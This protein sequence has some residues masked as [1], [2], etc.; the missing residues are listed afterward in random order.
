[1]FS[2]HYEVCRVDLGV[3]V[4]S[5]VCVFHWIVGCGITKCVSVL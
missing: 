1:M 4:R 3:L 5:S 2:S